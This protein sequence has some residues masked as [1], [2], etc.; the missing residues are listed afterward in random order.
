VTDELFRRDPRNPILTAADLPYAANTAFNPGVARLGDETLLLVR[1]EDRSGRSHLAV[2]TSAD[3]ATGWQIDPARAL[4][5]DPAHPEELYGLED[6][7]ITQLEDGGFAILYTGYSAGGPLVCLATTADFR[8]Y[9]RHGVVLPPEN[10]DAAVFPRRVA[11]TYLMLHRPVSAHGA[12]VWLARSPDLRHWG[13]HMRLFA[14]RPIGFWDGA[15][16]G[17]GPPPLETEAGWLVAYHGVR[18]TA[19]GAIYRVGLALLDLE[20]PDRVL[21]RTDDWVF[22]PREPYELLGD[23]GNVV[24]PCGWLLD[25]DVVR[26]YYGAADTSVALAEARLGELLAALS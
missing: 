16:I 2:A 24:F 13:G 18:E 26:L 14:T 7:R 25:G 23:V 6:P 1:V 4:H 15:K 9:V 19:A 21:A 10:K 11:G 20:R 8:R 17:V 5:A 3:G 12:D 22:G